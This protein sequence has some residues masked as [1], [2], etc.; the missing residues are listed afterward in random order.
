MKYC[1]LCRPEDRD[2][3]TD[4]LIEQIQAEYSDVEV[5]SVKTHKLVPE[6]DFLLVAEEVV[7]LTYSP[8]LPLYNSTLEV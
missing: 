3:V 7:P 2:R 8:Y 1:L 5:T 4:T 6:G